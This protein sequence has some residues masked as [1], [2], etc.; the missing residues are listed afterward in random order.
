MIL[1]YHHVSPAGDDS[2][3]TEPNCHITPHALEAQILRLLHLGFRFVSTDTMVDEIVQ[4]GYVSPRTAAITLDDGWADNYQYAFPVFLKYRVPAT[5]FITTEHLNRRVLDDRKM[6]P[7]QVAEVHRHGMSVGGHTRRHPDL[8]ALSIDE[9]KEEIRGCKTDIEDVLGAPASLFAYP[10]G[11]F[12]RAIAD[13][14]EEAGY[15]AACSVIGVGINRRNS[16]FWLHRDVLTEGMNT[17]ADTVRLSA[18]L[19]LALSF[20]TK[21]RVHLQLTA[22]TWLS[23][24]R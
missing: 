14:V 12:N 18:L 21:R 6:S 8:L 2:V 1:M 7:Q 20:R 24:P 5:F 17:L 16:L 3:F 15:K 4:H 23:N 9:A 13:L 11:V 10:G 19:R 22:A